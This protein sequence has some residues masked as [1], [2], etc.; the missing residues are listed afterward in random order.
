MSFESISSKE[1]VARI[2]HTCIWCGDLILPKEKYI[3]RTY[4]FEGVFN[5]DKAHPECVEAMSNSYDI[6]EGFE[7]HQQYR[8]KTLEESVALRGQEFAP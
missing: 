6:S 4:R 8:G 3:Y 7:P 2:N 5:H 1:I